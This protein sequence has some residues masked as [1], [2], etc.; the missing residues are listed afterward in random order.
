MLYNTQNFT[1]P[2]DLD[3]QMYDAGQYLIYV[4]AL[5]KSFTSSVI[6]DSEDVESTIK[7][8]LSQFNVIDPLES[9]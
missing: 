4:K 5:D 9:L 1:G 7:I 3:L 8:A 2:V 6:V